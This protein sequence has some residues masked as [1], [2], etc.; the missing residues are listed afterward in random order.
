[1]RESW[2]LL[3]PLKISLFQT[4]NRKSKSTCIKL[5]CGSHNTI[6]MDGWN[7]NCDRVVRLMTLKEYYQR[8]QWAFQRFF[9]F[10]TVAITLC[11]VSLRHYSTRISS[12]NFIRA[13][14]FRFYFTC[15]STLSMY[16]FVARTRVRAILEARLCITRTLQLT[17]ATKT[18]LITGISEAL[19]TTSSVVAELL[20]SI[21]STGGGCA[22]SYTEEVTLFGGA[23][24]H[25]TI[26]TCENTRTDCTLYLEY[27]ANLITLRPTT[28][29]SIT[30]QYAS[31]GAIFIHT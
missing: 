6:S 31:P 5:H 15:Y 22:V 9:E 21:S 23:T 30:P 4:A 7:F 16:F 8:Y 26:S 24:K 20:T 11:N 10:Y 27:L 28:P 17:V 25:L 3:L 12:R 29:Q 14:E 1:M 2:R 19:Q 13:L 18:S